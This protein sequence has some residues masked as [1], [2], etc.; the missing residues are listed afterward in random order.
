MIEIVQKMREYGITLDELM[1]R[2]AGTQPDEPPAKYVTR[3]P[4]RCEADA[5]ARA[6]IV[7]EDRSEFI[8]VPNTGTDGAV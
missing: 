7:G 1:R 4:A 5:G 3:L 2:K 6:W 8:D